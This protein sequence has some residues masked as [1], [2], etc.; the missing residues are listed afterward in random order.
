[1]HEL[2]LQQGYSFVAPPA[3]LNPI[4]IDLDENVVSW[5]VSSLRFT[6]LED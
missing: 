5:H 2:P 6:C 1:M 4:S 3:S